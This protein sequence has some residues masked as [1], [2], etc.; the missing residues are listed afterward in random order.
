M[1]Y[2]KKNISTKQIGKSLEEDFASGKIIINHFSHY[3]GQE[4]EGVECEP[5]SAEKNS[6]NA[7]PKQLINTKAGFTLI[8]ILVVIGIISVLALIVLVAINPAR[9]FALSR[10]TQ[11][12]SNVNSILNAIGQNMVDNK[13]IFTCASGS[14]PTATTNMADYTSD[15]NGFD[16]APCL[17][18]TYLPALPFDPSATGSGWVSSSSYNTNYTVAQDA[19][20]QRITVCAPTLEPSVGN[21]AICI[22]R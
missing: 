13:G 5:G 2:K 14:L 16:I 19:T 3:D 20:T 21:G 9:Q 22:T 18:P 11:R 1:K 8:E 4:E 6:I 15:S 7:L 10:N 12:T 17:T